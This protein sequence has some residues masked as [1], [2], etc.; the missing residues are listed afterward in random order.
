MIYYHP[1]V[2]EEL[3]LKVPTTWPQFMDVLNQIKDS[4]TYIPYAMGG[5]D[6]WP[7]YPFNEFMPHLASEDENYLS[8]IAGQDNPF[9]EGTPF[10]HE[11]SKIAELYQAGVM[12]HDPLGVSW[13]QATGLFESKKAAIIGAGLWYLDTYLTKVGNTDDL[14]GFPLPV[15]DSEDQPLT[16]MTMVDFFYGVAQNSKHADEAKKF[17]EWF[18]GPDMYQSYIDKLKLDSTMEGAASTF[19]FL[20]EYAEQNQYTPFLYIPGNDEYTKLVNATQLDWKKLGQEMM[21]GTK[22]ADISKEWNDKW[23]NNKQ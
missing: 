16:V 11:Y 2:F 15:R 6:A 19:P 13:D 17:L 21:S 1:S 10:Y 22:L 12:G 23:A 20:K 14:A 7:N 18:F 9:A 8:S 5:K 4:K 3:G